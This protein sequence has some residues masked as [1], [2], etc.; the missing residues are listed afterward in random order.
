[1]RY[2]LAISK[3]LAQIRVSIQD[4]FYLLKKRGYFGSTSSVWKNPLLLYATLQLL[5]TPRVCLTRCLQHTWMWP[6]WQ[7]VQQRWGIPG[8]SGPFAF[9]F[10]LLGSNG[11]LPPPA[12]PEMNTRRVGTGQPLPCRWKEIIEGKKKITIKSK[13]WLPFL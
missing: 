11:S 6:F 12:E 7:Q 8:C 2:S 1:M 9:R 4:Y 3:Y 5:L 10:A 13:R